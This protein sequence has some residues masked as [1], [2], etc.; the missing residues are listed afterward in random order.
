MSEKPTASHDPGEDPQPADLSGEPATAPAAGGPALLRSL[1]ARMLALTMAFIIFG[2]A[3]IFMPSIAGFRL[4]WLKNRMAMAELA[5]LAVEAAP[6]QRLSDNMR[7]ELLRSAGV[8]VVAIKRGG[9]R[10]LVLHDDMPQ[11][12]EARYDLRNLSWWRSIVDAFDTLVHGGRRIITVVD[13]PP[14]VKAEFM[15]LAM[16]ERPLFRALINHSLLILKYSLGLA[17]LVALLLYG[18]IHL[19]LIRPIR[20]LS[21]AMVRFAEDP[22]APERIITP[23]RRRD[24]LGIAERELARMQ[25]QTAEML[26]QK[27]RLA[28]LGLAVSK[29]AHE[30]RNMLG[31]AQLISDRLAM[32]DD[33]TV[34]KFAPKLIASLSRAIDFCAGTLKYGRVQEAPPRR[35]TLLLRPLADDVL[36]GMP[37]DAARPV[38]MVNRIGEGLAADA[39]PDQLY[40]ILAN[41]VR[42]AHQALT[43]MAA[44]EGEREIVLDAWRDGAVVTIA[45]MDNGPGLPAKARKHLFEPFTGSTRRGGTGLGLSIARELAQAHGGDIVLAPHDGPGTVFHVII[46]DRAISL[47]EARRHRSG[48]QNAS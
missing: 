44:H 45:V 47:D 43:A 28:A 8:R 46:P 11:M 20:R 35:R 32:V 41:L 22:E 19:L 48:A 34:K 6:N 15:E 2:V 39:D 23:S 42:N 40:R 26:K 27:T 38:R 29:I 36:E 4:T 18:A 3:V 9:A 1:S 33:P 30:L 13:A 25:R 31:S 7:R 12:A 37:A 10:Q 14:N 17:L 16:D 24:E 21:R 5:Y